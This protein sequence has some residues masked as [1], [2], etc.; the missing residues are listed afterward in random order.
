MIES[1]KGD[2]SGSLQELIS[3]DL[4]VSLVNSWKLQIAKQMN[5]FKKN[6]HFWGRS[7]RKLEWDKCH[8]I[9]ILKSSFPK[10]F[11]NR[12]MPSIQ[13]FQQIKSNILITEILNP[14]RIAVARISS[15]KVFKSSIRWYEYSGA[16]RAIIP[17]LQGHRSGVP[18][19][20]RNFRFI[21]AQKSSVPHL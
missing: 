17:D 12:L 4:A 1:W 6:C 9:Q 10:P 3:A 18:R 20:S 2:R 7:L 5:N 14:T 13:S 21:P 19:P 16:L 11:T 15:S 8:D